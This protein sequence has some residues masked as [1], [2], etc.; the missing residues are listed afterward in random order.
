MNKQLV[1]YFLLAAMLAGVSCGSSGTA[2]D[3]T[4]ADTTETTEAETTNPY[5]PGLPDADYNGETFTFA[6][7][8]DGQSFGAWHNHDIK[9]EEQNGETLNDA[10]YERTSFIEDKYNINIDVLWA[11]ET[12]LSLHDGAMAKTINQLVLVDDDTVDCIL[13]SPYTTVGFMMDDYLIDLNTVEHLDLSKPWWDQNANES[14]SFGDKIFFTTGELT[15]IDNKCAY[16]VIF[17]KNMVDMFDI[18]DPYEAVRSGKWTLDKMIADSQKV[19]S[20]LNGD[21]KMDDKDRYGYISWQDN[22]FG[23]IH[24]AGNQF[25][26]INEN[27]EPELTL[28]TERLVNTWEKV[29]A[30]YQS[31]AQLSLK[32]NHAYLS[33]AGDGT[34]EGTIQYFLENDQMLYSYAQVNTILKLRSSSADFGIIPLPKY[35][36]AQDRYYTTSHG[37]GTTLMS[38]PITVKDP[39]RSGL[40]L[41][42]FSAKSA[43]IVT[44]AFYDITL[45]GKT[46][47]DE[48]SKEMLDIIFSTKVYD[49]GYFFQWGNLTNRILTAAQSRNGDI[50]SI[51][52]SAKERALSDL[53]EAKAIFLTLE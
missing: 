25:A 31:D 15:Y 11:G 50:A 47:R 23:F 3:T 30:F 2:D 37:Y 7:R 24:S 51:Y 10:V 52:E 19:Y 4:A 49:I 29:F 45:T 40:I 16:T 20:D 28:Y 32:S 18:D 36:E 9:V 43:E 33:S 42:A 39:A 12:G 5:D 53:E 1:T 14:L 17:S 8:G 48:D 26:V 41:E 46:V 22:V 27:G 38:I 44:P 13:S 21:S 34:F 6:V 35:D